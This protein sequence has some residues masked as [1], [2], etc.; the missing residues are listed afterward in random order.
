M[1]RTNEEIRL[2]HRLNESAV[3][4][5]NRRALFPIAA[6]LRRERIDARRKFTCTL[7]LYLDSLFMLD[8]PFEAP[9]ER[10]GDKMQR[11]SGRERTRGERDRERER[12]RERGGREKGEK[13]EK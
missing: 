13:R 3:N 7:Q 6:R 4:Y 11:R 5:R 10:S 1:K 8:L 9:S 2:K 12:L